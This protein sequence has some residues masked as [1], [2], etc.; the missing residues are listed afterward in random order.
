MKRSPHYLK[1]SVMNSINRRII[2]PR[3]FKTNSIVDFINDCKVIYSLSNR[4]ERGFL[5]DLSKVN[6]C[7]MIGVLLVYKII[8]FS[9][10]NN[11]FIRPAYLMSIEFQKALEKY[12]FTNLILTY[13]ADKSVAEKE[14]INLKVSISDSFIIAPQALLRNDKY[15][16]EVLN[17]RYLPQIDCYYSFNPKVVKM[18]FLCFSEILL[19]FWEHAVDDTQSIIVA[20]GNKSIIE[21]ACADNGKGVLSTLSLAGKTKKNELS[22]FLSAIEKGVTSKELMS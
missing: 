10:K 14:F 17:K 5:L 20:N 13:L 6:E 4:K 16:S 22:T 2:A 8:E 15:S 12:G 7:S 1:D 9:I 21:I 3:H 18:I 19:N 11:C